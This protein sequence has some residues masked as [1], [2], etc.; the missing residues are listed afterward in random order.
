MA[1]LDLGHVEETSGVA[2]QRATREVEARDRLKAPLVERPQGEASLRS[3]RRPVVLPPYGMPLNCFTC[4]LAMTG[5]GI[6]SA[7][8]RI[9]S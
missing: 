4:P 7:A 2:D 3:R 6:V 1:T 5:H 8:C 9:K